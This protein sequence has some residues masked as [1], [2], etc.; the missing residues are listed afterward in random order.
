MDPQD[1]RI[2]EIYRAS[3]Q[4]DYRDRRSFRSTFHTDCRARVDRSSR[5][6]RLALEQ[7]VTL[8]RRISQSVDLRAR[9]EGDTR[10][11]VRR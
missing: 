5:Q 4:S 8:G 10:S 7:G 1:L 11:V 2:W 9:N 6:A 3:Y